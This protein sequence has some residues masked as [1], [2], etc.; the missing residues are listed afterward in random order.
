MQSTSSR[1][2]SQPIYFTTCPCQIPPITQ[3]HS[4]SPTGEKNPPNPKTTYMSFKRSSF[5]LG[6]QR[7]RRVYIY[8]HLYNQPSFLLP[9]TLQPALQ[10]RHEQ[11]HGGRAPRERRDRAEVVAVLCIVHEVSEDLLFRGRRLTVGDLVRD[12]ES[13][14]KR[15]RRE[16]GEGSPRVEFTLWG[17]VSSTSRGE[18]EEGGNTC[19]EHVGG[20]LRPPAGHPVDVV[21]LRTLGKVS[22]REAVRELAVANLLLV[23]QRTVP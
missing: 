3:N 5:I 23:L 18:E 2:R 15:L 16:R 11:R 8:I 6:Q 1:S 4:Q 12:L 10:R 14:R 7:S 17:L 19:P 22:R 21:G 13:R 9:E 20:S